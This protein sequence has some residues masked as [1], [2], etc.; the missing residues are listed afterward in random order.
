MKEGKKKNKTQNRERENW[1]RD[2][3]RSY[4]YIQERDL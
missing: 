1:L 3:I 2:I 4:M